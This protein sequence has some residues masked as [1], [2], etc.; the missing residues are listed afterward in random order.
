[1][2]HAITLPT[3]FPIGPVNVYLVESDILTLVDAG[4]YTDEAWRVLTS[5]LNE[6]GYVPSDIGQVLL[7]HHHPDHVGLL[8]YLLEENDRMAILGHWK[9]NPWLRRDPAFLEQY[10][11]FLKNLYRQFGVPEAYVGQADRMMRRWKNDAH[12]ARLTGILRQ[13]DPVP[14]LNGWFV[15]ETPGHAQTHLAMVREKDG[16]WIA[17]DHILKSIS[18]NAMIEAPY[19]GEENERPK[20]LLQYRKALRALLGEK[21]SIVYTGHGDPVDDAHA[22]IEKRLQQHEKRTADIL[23]IL[24]ARC[25]SGFEICQALFPSLYESQ[26]YLT[27][28]E[29]LGHMDLLQARRKVELTT[30][31]G[32]DRFR[33]V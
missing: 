20:T 23:E 7:T 18:S 19:P 25:L 15:M 9:M 31:D 24:G 27:L 32:V 4:P 8:P 1:M 33:R 29:T 12:S 11:A 22:L 6:L 16:V 30:Q 21:I 14:G 2:I 28:S 26:F 13:G 5:P 17:G 3:P 10:G